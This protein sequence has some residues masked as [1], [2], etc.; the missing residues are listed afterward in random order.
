MK[1]PVFTKIYTVSLSETEN[2]ID[3]VDTSYLMG[4]ITTDNGSYIVYSDLIINQDRTYSFK[5]YDIKGR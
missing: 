1:H 5:F 4:E 2:K 3:D